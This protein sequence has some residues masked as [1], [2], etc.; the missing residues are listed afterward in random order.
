[1]VATA[2]RLTARGL[3]VLGAIALISA[4]VAPAS[5]S[6]Y[7]SLGLAL[8][9]LALLVTLSRA[10]MLRASMPAQGGLLEYKSHPVA[11]HVGFA[12]AVVIFGFVF[13]IL[14]RGYISG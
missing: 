1:M 11:Y 13:G 8:W 5:L 14:I 10:Y 2:L 7:V 12:V 6:A 3:V 9:V 4:V